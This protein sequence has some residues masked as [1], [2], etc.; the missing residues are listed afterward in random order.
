MPASF[1]A[2]S[3]QHWDRS[4]ARHTAQVE[5]IKLLVT[6][7][8]GIA[9][10]LV[11]TALQVE[12]QNG[13]DKSAVAMLAIAFVLTLCAVGLDRLK[14]PDRQ[15]ALD[16]QTTNTWTEAQLLRYLSGKMRQ[17]H[18]ENEIVVSSVRHAAEFQVLFSLAAA[19]FAATS[20][21]Q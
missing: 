13:W 7:T 18:G 20:L 11:A 2:W 15:T 4:F 5:T 1:D 14:W 16:L 21:L 8:L 3:D 17:A 9:G 10:T 19:G 12:P 6:F